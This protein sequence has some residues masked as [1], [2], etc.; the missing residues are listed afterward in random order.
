ML[1]APRPLYVDRIEEIGQALARHP[2]SVVD[3][4]SGYRSAGEV[5]LE[6]AASLFTAGK[7]EAAL[8]ACEQAIAL[9]PSF[10]AD[11]LRGQI[12][13]GL[14]RGDEARRAF[15]FALSLGGDADEQAFVRALLRTMETEEGEG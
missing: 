8:G 11:K 10:A 4:V 15:E 3:H 1:S 13:Q 12:L 14:G 2:V 7:D 9:E 5:T 6:Q